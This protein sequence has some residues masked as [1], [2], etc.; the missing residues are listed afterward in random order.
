MPK[1]SCPGCGRAIPFEMHEMD[2]VI[3]CAACGT[4]FTALGG[5]VSEVA[6][7]PSPLP[8]CPP[9]RQSPSYTNYPTTNRRKNGLGFVASVFGVLAVGFFVVGWVFWEVYYQSLPSGTKGLVRLA[10]K[11]KPIEDPAEGVSY[12][13]YYCGIGLSVAGLFLGVVSFAEPNRNRT[14]SIVGTALNG[15]ALLCVVIALLAR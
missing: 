8:S 1:A 2:L 4:R 13:L 15:V 6:R 5:I 3:E 12:A 9:L 7:A 10:I 11:V 14:Y